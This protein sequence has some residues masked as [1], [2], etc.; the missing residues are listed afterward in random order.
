[1]QDPEGISTES[2][3]FQVDPPLS[4]RIPQVCHYD[5]G[6]LALTSTFDY[7]DVGI[8][9]SITNPRGVETKFVVNALDQ[10]VVTISV[11]PAFGC[12]RSTT[13]MASWNVKSETHWDD[14]GN[15]LPDGPR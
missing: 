12:D 13:K 8:T 1:V 9:T 7:N 6:G 11:G 5:V 10:K 3:Y 14:Q 2:R 4:R 15:S